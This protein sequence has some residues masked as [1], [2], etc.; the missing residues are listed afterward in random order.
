VELR[1]LR[2][3]GL[4]TRRGLLAQQ[5]F[6]AFSS[7]VLET[8]IAGRHPYQVGLGW[9]D[10][11]DRAMARWALAAVGMEKNAG[12]DVLQLSGGEQQRVALATLLAQNPDLLLLDEPTAH[13]DA[14]AQL[15]VMGLARGLNARDPGAAGRGKAGIAALPDPHPGRGGGKAAA[16]ACPDINLVA[17]F[18]TH[19]LAL[20]RETHWAGPTDTVLVPSVLQQAFGCRFDMADTPH[21]RLFVPVAAPGQMPGRRQRE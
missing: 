1:A 5:Q 3:A 11:D 9:E 10:D 12:K 8:V 4:G 17:G 6:D 20:G 2:P 7:T 15:A 18:A 19:V 14:A 13:Q 16:P 21:G